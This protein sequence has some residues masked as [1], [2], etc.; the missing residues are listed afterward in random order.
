MSK[1]TIPT[2]Y[3]TP[4]GLITYPA[5]HPIVMYDAITLPPIRRNLPLPT[6]LVQAVFTSDPSGWSTFRRTLAFPS[7]SSFPSLCS[8]PRIELVLQQNKVSRKCVSNTIHSPLSSLPIDI[9]YAINHERDVVTKF[10]TT[11]QYRRI[12]LSVLSVVSV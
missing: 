7:L 2:A 8:F 6:V 12:E 3:L 10:Q 4:Q 11:L 5:N 9:S 1:D